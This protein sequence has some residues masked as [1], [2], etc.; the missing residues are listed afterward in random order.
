MQKEEVVKSQIDFNN[1]MNKGSKISNNFFIIFKNKNDLNK[2]L[3]GIA[4]GKKL[5]N[6]V[7]RNKLKRQIRMIITQ[8]KI[9][10]K[11]GFSYIILVKKS[12]LTLKYQEIEQHI[13]ELIRKENI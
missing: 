13:I 7:I 10:F 3:F 9:L 12:C 5:G 11:S 8:N 2:S 1:I 4:V 6:A